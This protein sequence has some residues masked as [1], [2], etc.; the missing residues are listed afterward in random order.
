MGISAVTG[1]DCEPVSLA[2]AREHCRIDDSDNDGLLAGYIL[3]ARR[4]AEN[5]TRRAFITQTWD[6][7]FDGDW[8]RERGMPAIWL[9]LPPLAS[10]TSVTYVDDGGQT[11][12]LPSDQY[13]VL[14]DGTFGR[15][16]P[17]DG[18]SWP[19]VRR[20]D[21]AITVRFIAG[22][23]AAAVPDEIRTAIL[24]HTELLFDR[25]PAMQP[26]L[27]SSRD[28]LLDHYRVVRVL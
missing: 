8:P 24:L 17:A 16:V 20:Q 15:I 6:A 9:P 21:N 22:W 13:R 2:H 11:Q 7:T 4:Y 3:A 5:Y 25:D 12:T 18:V 19:T 14:T 23:D 10:V 28:A 27:E 26:S 1:P